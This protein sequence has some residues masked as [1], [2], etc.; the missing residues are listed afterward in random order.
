MKMS[1]G[2]EWGYIPKFGDLMI[3]VQSY[4]MEEYE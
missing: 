1:L 3:V 2:W 4:D